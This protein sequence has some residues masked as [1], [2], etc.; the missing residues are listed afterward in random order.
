VITVTST[1]SID[2]AASLSIIRAHARR[3]FERVSALAAR[4]G[5]RGS[6]GIGSL[7]APAAIAVAALATALLV[8]AGAVALGPK[9]LAAPVA[10]GIAVVL[11][12]NPPVLL[13]LFVYLVYF[14]SEPFLANLPVDI[15]V[16]LGA[17]MTGVIAVRISM[18]R[19]LR[20]PAGLVIP[21]LVI[22]VALAVGLLWTP[23]PGYG[24]A[25][26]FKF[27]TSTVIAIAAP[28]VVFETRR[29][30]L[31]FLGATAGIALI[32]AAV[33]PFY[34]PQVL[35]GITA[36]SAN[37]GRFAFGGQIF[38]ARLLT[39]AALILLF[40]PS[41]TSLRPRWLWPL[42]AVGVLIVALGLGSR[43]PTVAFAISLVTMTALS[44]T[45]NPRYLVAVLM[46]ALLGIA[47]FPFI[48]LPE[49][50]SQRLQQAASEPVV[51]L[52]DDVRSELYAEAVTI[53][54]EHPLKGIG[55][56]GYSVFSAVL[57][58]QEILYPHNVF[59]ELSS[60]L[61]LVIPMFF[62]AS[63]IGAFALMLRRAG[64]TAALRDR[65]LV[66][67][68]LALLLLNLLG[69]QFSGD[70]NDNRSMW[71]FLAIVWMVARHG[72]PPDAPRS[73]RPPIVEAE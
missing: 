17:L 38:P 25:K 16:V 39:T 45:R 52:N 62:V 36:A 32:A 53:T 64:V 49:T 70:I 65:Q 57:A 28:F 12:R 20:P 11:V 73:A 31:Q 21:V 15:S 10:I 44:A 9:A 47:V 34:T 48:S 29:D 27:F 61:G 30:L 55:T 35:T 58:K 67:L 66:L 2:H 40:A 41:F 26:V 14:K 13:A 69:A 18:G 60:E 7:A 72:V 5:A 33:T 8:G 50:A 3:P 59:L 56:G 54:D 71:L 19:H 6:G 68:L 51:V 43:G 23:T 1:F 37:E 46:V 4:I 22:G 42:A 24:S 63:L